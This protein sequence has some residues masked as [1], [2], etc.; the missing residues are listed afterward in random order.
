VAK[1]FE[2]GPFAIT[3]TAGVQGVVFD[4]STLGEY[5]L[6]ADHQTIAQFRSRASGLGGHLAAIASRSENEFV[7]KSVMQA[8]NVARSAAIGLSDEL[9]E[10]VLRWDNNQPVS[11][12]FF[13]QNQPDN[14]NGIEDHFHIYDPLAGLWN[15]YPDGAYAGLFGVAESDRAILA[16]AINPANAH[17]YLLFRASS[18]QGAQARAAAMGG[19]LVTINDVAEN[20][21]VRTTFGRPPSGPARTIWI[22]LNDAATEGSFRWADNSTSFFRNFPSGRPD[23]RWGEQDYVDLDPFSG[24]WDDK[25]NLPGLHHG[26]AE[27]TLPP[28]VGEPV[29][30]PTG[31]GRYILVGPTN[32]Y[33]ALFLAQQLGG[34]LLSIDSPEENEFIRATFADVGPGRRLWLG[35]TDR[36]DDGNFTWFNGRPFAYTNF[37]AGEPNN[38]GGNEDYLE[39]FD[40]VTGVWND[41]STLDGSAPLHFAIIELPCACEVPCRCDWNSDSSLNSQDFFD[42]LS[43][44]FSGP[45]DFNCDS[46]TNSQDFFDFLGCFFAPPA[47]CK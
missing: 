3:A 42:F 45:A 37:L 44:F 8:E 15:D 43:S 10:G 30:A 40:P 18:W 22:G 26:V 19:N 14:T 20:E 17:L 41:I 33:P 46:V 29:P 2:A 21:F 7:T 38:W 39:M 36:D 5:Y 34:Q 12:T 35:A 4:P 23:D 24:H 28:I 1:L 16:S 6:L 47:G 25:P 27:I 32:L 9:E 11:F 31:C 13:G